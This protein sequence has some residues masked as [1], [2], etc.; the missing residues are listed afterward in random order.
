MLSPTLELTNLKHQKVKLAQMED[1]RPTM[2]AFL[3]KSHTLVGVFVAVCLFVLALV[4][5]IKLRSSYKQGKRSTAKLHSPR[6][7]ECP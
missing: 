6:P 4:L 2:C 1:N 3:E 7:R 5:E